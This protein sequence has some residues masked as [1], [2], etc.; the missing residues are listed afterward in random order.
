[1]KHYRFDHSALKARREKLG[2][3]M[4]QVAL[5][6]R[7]SDSAYSDYETGK[8]TPGSVALAKLCQ[9]LQLRTPNFI[10]HIPQQSPES[11]S[12]PAQHP[13]PCSENP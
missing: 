12:P 8:R 10:T 4:K 2:L 7:I 13:I 3:T 11:Q 6:C 1:M 9:A 5:R